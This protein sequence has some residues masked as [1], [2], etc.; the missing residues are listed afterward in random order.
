MS[1][2]ALP[3]CSKQQFYDTLNVLDHWVEQADFQWDYGLDEMLDDV[4]VTPHQL[5]LMFDHLIT[6][7]EAHEKCSDT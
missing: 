1:N 3:P 5:Y 2:L 7:M 6:I 4:D